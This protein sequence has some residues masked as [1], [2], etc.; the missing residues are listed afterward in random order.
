M[1]AR[2]LE[3]QITFILEIDKLKKVLRQTV[4]TDGS[5]QENSVEHSWHIAIMALVL[6][7][8]AQGSPLDLLRVVSMLLIHDLVEIDAGDTCCYDGEGT[9]DQ[10]DREIRAADRL[11]KLLPPDQAGQIRTLWDEFEEGTTPEA[12]FAAALDRL[13]PL[14]HN[15]STNGIMWRKHG[16]DKGQVVARNDFIADGAPDLWDFAAYLIDDAVDKGILAE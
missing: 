11:F 8:Y 10:R 2:R 4:L 15:Y 16:I 7:E 6:M 14:L 1:N 13:Q 9:K 12:R 3:Q 5:R